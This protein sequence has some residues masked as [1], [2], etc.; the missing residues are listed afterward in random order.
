MSAMSRI[1]DTGTLLRG[2]I[3]RTDFALGSGYLPLGPR[4]C[5]RLTEHGLIVT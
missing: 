3:H 4:C 5:G 1:K 2:F